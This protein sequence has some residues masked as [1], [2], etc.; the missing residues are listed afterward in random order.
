MLDHDSCRRKWWMPI[1][2][3]CAMSASHR[4]TNAASL[5]DGEV[6]DDTSTLGLIVSPENLWGGRETQSGG[7][8]VCFVGFSEDESEKA[9]RM[10]GAGVCGDL[11]D[12]A[13]RL[14]EDLACAV[15]LLRRTLQLEADFA[16][17]N[18]ADDEARM[19][20]RQGVAACG[21]IYLSHGDVPVVKRD[22]RQ[23]VLE[24][25]VCLRRLAFGA[26]QNAG[27]ED[28]PPCFEETF[29]NIAPGYHGSTIDL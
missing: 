22:W 11:M 12:A 6:C 25:R 13:G 20:V 4:R 19:A 2:I 10:L 14:V 17:E 29:D 7:G 24:D 21:I 26:S 5:R 18:I 1:Q 16:F 8:A 3:I 28:R 23:L 9:G 15:G 27:A